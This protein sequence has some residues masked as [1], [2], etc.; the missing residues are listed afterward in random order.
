MASWKACYKE[1]GID[2]RQDTEEKV[3]LNLVGSNLTEIITAGLNNPECAFYVGAFTGQFMALRYLIVVLIIF[4][5]FKIIEK[6]AFEPFI[7][8]VKNKVRGGK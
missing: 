8:W 1:V 6:L 2:R 7:S 4:F 3:N 5:V